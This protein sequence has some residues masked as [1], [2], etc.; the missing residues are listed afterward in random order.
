MKKR[1]THD[2]IRPQWLLESIET[3]FLLPIE[4]RYALYLRPEV[5]PYAEANLDTFGD[6]YTTPISV[7]ELRKVR[8][9]VSLI[10]LTWRLCRA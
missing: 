10:H 1:A 4:P 2:I 7:E 6:S 3:G 9:P 5:V 8:S